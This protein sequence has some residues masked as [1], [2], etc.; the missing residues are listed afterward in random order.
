MSVMTVLGLVKPDKLGIVLPHEHVFIDLR[1]QFSEPQEISKKILADQQ[2]NIHN[3]G[4]LKRN[5]YA[6]KDNLLLSDFELA[7]EELKEFKKAGGKTIVDHTSRGL[8][9]DPY[10]LKSLAITIGLNIIVG[11]GYYTYDTHPE[12]MNKKSVEELTD[13][14]LKDL[15]IGIKKSGVRAGIIG[16]LGT[17]REIHPNEKKVLLAAA[18]AH[19]KTGAPI[20]VH[21]YP[22]KHN[23]R[24]IVNMFHEKNVRL[25]K[26]I[27]CHS[28]VSI[29]LEYMRDILSKGALIEFDNFGKEFYM[30]PEDRGFA[31]GVFATDIERIRTI[32]L[33]IDEGFEKQ[34]LI[35]ND[36]CLKMMLHRYG[37]WGYD[38]ILRNI[39]PMMV[40]EGITEDIIDLLL[41]ENPKRLLDTI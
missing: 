32:K 30:S 2:V 21:T 37:G 31:G 7:G 9:R 19:N 35:S 12:D 8:G 27:I 1:N 34:I 17:S 38:H 3:L 29:N 6:I 41:R 22:W 4:I 23:G 26:V 18:R 40:D 10:L 20:S 15:T 24:E 28:D 5:P 14:I 39:V 13:E 36:L 11:S 25:D 33:L 16:E